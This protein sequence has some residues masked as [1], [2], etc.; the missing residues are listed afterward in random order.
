MPSMRHECLVDLFK[1]RPS[2]GAELLAEVLGIALPSYTDARLISIDLTEIRPAEYRA[3]V[4]VL[5]LDGDIPIW[6]LIVEVQLGIAPRKRFTWPDYTMGA[7]AA[8]SCPVG[9]LVVAPDPVVAAWCAE[10]IETGIPGF[11][12]HPP[13]LGRDAIPVVTSPDEA[14]RRPELAVLS[15]M[16]H[17]EGEQGAAIAAAVLPAIR[18]LD[19]EKAKF[20]GDLVLSCLNEAARKALETMMKGYEYQS[21]F[22]KKY[23]AQGRQEGEL[24][25]LLRQLRARFGEL[26]A[27][28]VTRI[29]AA[30]IAEIE[31][32][33]ERVLSARTLAEV[34]DEPS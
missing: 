31:R 34:L 20:Y 3:D 23:V 24:N 5:L 15:A 27:A 25:L 26:P 14:A 19:D 1:N 30:D 10:P 16:A 32:W 6:V 33:G 11:V 29:E 21:D 13:V 4:V 18:E 9:L 12:L 7:R 28:A 2:L 22:A 8:H 17:G